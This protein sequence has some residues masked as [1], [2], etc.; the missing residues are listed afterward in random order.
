MLTGEILNFLGKSAISI[1]RTRQL[2][3][4]ADDAIVYT[5]TIIVLQANAITHILHVC[6]RTETTLQP[7]IRASWKQWEFDKFVLVLLRGNFQSTLI[8]T[9]LIFRRDNFNSNN[10]P[11]L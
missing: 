6:T 2:S 7:K 1:D 4:L 8:S 11:Y 10:F 3:T 9:T 5:Y